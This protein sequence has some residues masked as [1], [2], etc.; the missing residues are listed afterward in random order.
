LKYDDN[1]KLLEKNL[2]T[3]D[4]KN[5]LIETIE[6]TPYKKI[7]TQIVRDEAGNAITQKEFNREGNLNHDVERDYD[8]FGNV[9]EVRSFV[10]GSGQRPDRKYILRYDYEFFED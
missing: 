6:E 8:E 2:Y 1:G 4:D 7:T 9:T 10:S 5:N 3:Y